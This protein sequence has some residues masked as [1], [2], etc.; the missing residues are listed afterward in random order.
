MVPRPV[1]HAVSLTTNAS[2]DATGY[3]GVAYGRVQT[4]QYV[5][6]D[7]AAGVD[8]T[9]TGETSGLAVL[10]LTDQNAS[11]TFFPRA[12]VHG[13]TGTALTVSEAVTVAGERVKVVVAQGGD[14]KSG[15]VYVTVG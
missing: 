15:V 7:Y 13:P 2:G 5:K 12:L 14:T 1:R 4:V 9:V 10:A 8:I 3:T 6:T 11:G